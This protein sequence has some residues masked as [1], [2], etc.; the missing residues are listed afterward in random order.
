MLT[1][2]ADH[3]HHDPKREMD[4]SEKNMEGY[5]CCCCFFLVNLKPIVPKVSLMLVLNL[6]LND[7]K[8]SSNI[9]QFSHA[10]KNTPD[11]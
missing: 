1:R 11:K 5:L 10:R 6:M 3:G 9:Q 7:S 2:K 4:Q 8:T